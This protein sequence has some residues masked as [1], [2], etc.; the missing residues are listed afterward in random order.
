MNGEALRNTPLHGAANSGNL[1]VVRQ[2][3]ER[4]PDLDLEIRGKGGWTALHVAV[5]KGHLPVVEALLAAGA[6]IQAPMLY[7]AC[8]YGYAAVARVLVLAGARADFRD[9]KDRTAL[10]LPGAQDFAAELKA[11]VI[12][13]QGNS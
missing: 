7:T 13:N 8:E 11:I 12:D 10:D 3:L 2:L 6:Q 5:Y 4:D 9:A 1:A